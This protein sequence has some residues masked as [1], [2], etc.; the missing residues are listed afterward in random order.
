MLIPGRKTAL[1]KI[2]TFLLDLAER[3]SDVD[4]AVDIPMCR[5]TSPTI[6]V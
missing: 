2:A 3:A 1:E 4:G 5:A 6:S